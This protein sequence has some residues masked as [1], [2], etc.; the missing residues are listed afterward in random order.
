[1]VDDEAVGIG[2]SQ[3]LSSELSESIPIA[4]HVLGGG[5]RYAVSEFLIF[6]FLFLVS[7]TN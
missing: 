7:V 3:F 1:V 6:Y 2:E 5:N 4:A